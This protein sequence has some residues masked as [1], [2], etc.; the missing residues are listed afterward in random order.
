MLPV[1]DVSVDVLVHSANSFH[2]VGSSNV[3]S[4]FNSVICSPVNSVS[5]VEDVSFV[6]SVSSDYSDE[7][8]K[9]FNNTENTA[10]VSE[11]NII[12][13]IN[14]I[15]CD[16]SIDPIQ[17]GSV[18]TV[19][20]NSLKVLALNVCGLISKLRAP[21]LEEICE[22]YDILC[23]S[24]SKFDEFDNVHIQN[25]VQLPPVIRSGAK[26]KSG[27]VVVFAKSSS[28]NVLWFILKDVLYAPVL[29]GAMYIPPENSIYSS[30]D[31]F[32]VIEGDIL[33]FVAE[34]NPVKFASWAT[35]MRALELK[36]TLST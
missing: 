22:N 24:E 3:Y 35:L 32:D 6:Y 5:S 30:I 17:N 9:N 19:N 29:F 7:V 12:E 23:F 31:F 20:K 21:E 4:T 34:K 25:F 13:N 2:S 15:L 27:G 33:K 8:Y 11:S 14:P 36:M 28:E 18:P 1:S 26:C 10:L 16:N